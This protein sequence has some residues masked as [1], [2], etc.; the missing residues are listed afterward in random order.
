MSEP[1]LSNFQAHLIYLPSIGIVKFQYNGIILGK[2]IFA[3]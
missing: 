1:S 2:S 3:R